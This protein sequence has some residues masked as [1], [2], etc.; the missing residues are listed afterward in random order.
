MVSNYY[1]GF[2]SSNIYHNDDITGGMIDGKL[3]SVSDLQ[4]YA[5]LRGLDEERAKL[6]GILS[7]ATSSTY[8]LLNKPASNLTQLL[9]QY[10]D[11]N[12]SAP[13]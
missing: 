12:E 3:M 6:S 10:I 11:D 1:D 2:F 4:S 9:A 13:K 5:E 8:N 7:T